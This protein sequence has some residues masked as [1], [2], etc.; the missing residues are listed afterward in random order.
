MYHITWQSNAAVK[1]YFMMS[2]GVVAVLFVSICF[3]IKR[4]T[5]VVKSSNIP[6]TCIQLFC[7][8][9]LY[10]APC[11]FIGKLNPLYCTFR[12]VILG[13]L[14]T[15]IVGVVFTKVNFL[16]SIFQ[17]QTIASTRRAVFTKS[18]QYITLF[19]LLIGQLCV[20]VI[21]TA[22]VPI[23]VHEEVNREMLVVSQRC[24][25]QHF[26]VQMLC[27]ALLLLSCTIQAFRAR[28]LPQNFN[29]SRF[30]MF[31]CF[32]TLLIMLIWPLYNQRS[33]TDDKNAFINIMFIFACNTSLLLILY[34]Y[35][36]WVLI[37]RQDQ[38]DSRIFREQTFAIIRKKISLNSTSSNGDGN[39]SDPY[40]MERDGRRENVIY[41]VGR[42]R[43][44]SEISCGTLTSVVES[45]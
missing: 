37:F 19:L 2:I 42:N 14:G 4:K 13:C 34:G 28:K 39:R 12:P 16:L 33:T 35:K 18:S 26:R 21:H 43:S 8:G 30:I 41:M 22:Q 7:Q 36:I 9:L 25:S 6:M 32:T 11:M 24:S 15:V 17:L 1:I 10:V 27:V 40:T 38:N 5:P 20:Y 44:R 45:F 3:A 29:E 23:E 31:A